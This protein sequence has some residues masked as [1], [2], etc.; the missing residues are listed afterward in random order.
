[1]MTMITILLA[2][3]ITLL[4]SATLGLHS[5]PWQDAAVAFTRL[6]SRPGGAYIS[7]VALFEEFASLHRLLQV[8]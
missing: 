2:T 5:S 7:T 6:P 8:L 1:M 4:F 3:C